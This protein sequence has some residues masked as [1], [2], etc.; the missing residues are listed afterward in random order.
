MSAAVNLYLQ[1]NNLSHLF[2]VPAIIQKFYP[3]LR[4]HARAQRAN[5][6]FVAAS[7]KVALTKTPIMVGNDLSEWYSAACNAT[8]RFTLVH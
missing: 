6:L 4:S 7:T 8:P 1:S 5:N 3:P 2:L